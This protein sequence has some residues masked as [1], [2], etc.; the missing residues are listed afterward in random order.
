[1]N[2]VKFMKKLSTYKG[3]TLVE[4]LIVIGILGILLAIVLVALNP[5]KQFA[6]ADDTKRQSDVNAIL[7]AVHQYAADENGD[8]P[9]GITTTPTE[10][11]NAG[12]DICAALVPLYLAQLPVDPDTGDGSPVD[13]AGCVDVAG[14]LTGYEI[15]TSA[16]NNRV[17]VS[18]PDAEG[19]GVVISVTR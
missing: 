15:S 11:S 19:D 17:T 13:A 14:Y 16:T 12:A 3:F 5:A 8:L 4:L 10:I 6:Q 9:G 2:I 18:A 1:M 7:N